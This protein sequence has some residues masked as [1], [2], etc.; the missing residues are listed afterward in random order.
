MAHIDVYTPSFT[1]VRPVYSPDLISC[2]FFTFRKW[3]REHDIS[4]GV[5]WR[6]C[7]MACP[8]STRNLIM[9]DLLNFPEV[10]VRGQNFEF[11]KELTPV[12][13][14]QHFYS[15]SAIKTMFSELSSRIYADECFL[16]TFLSYI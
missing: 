1:G 15:S 16:V 4:W 8:H 9:F 13:L 11:V 10:E 3:G 5:R 7:E 14:F 2:D 12:F 6:P